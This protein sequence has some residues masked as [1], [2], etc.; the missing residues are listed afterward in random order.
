MSRKMSRWGASGGAAASSEQRLDVRDAVWKG[1]QRCIE[2]VSGIKALLLDTETAGVV[3]LVL[4]QTKALKMQVFSMD[5]LDNKERRPVGYIKAV[6]IIRPTQE[7]IRVLKRE[8]ESPNYDEYHVFF[9]NTLPDHMLKDLAQADFK[10]VGT[11]S[12]EL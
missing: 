1:V 3:G 9:T 8:L 11:I 6:C 4:S 10:Q 5:R 12:I 7:N 2:A